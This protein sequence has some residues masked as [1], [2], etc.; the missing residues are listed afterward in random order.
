M[1]PTNICMRSDRKWKRLEHLAYTVRKDIL[2]ISYNA[3]V[4]HI[5]PALS[6]VDILT[7]LYFGILRAKADRFILSKG[8]AAAAL[9]AVL[10]QKGHITKK[11][12]AT[13]CRQGGAFGDHPD[14]DPNRGI[15]LTTG[16]LGHGLSVGAGMA[17]GLSRGAGSRSAGPKS[18]IFVLISDAELNEGSIWEAAMFAGHHRLSNLTAIIDNN[19]QQAFGKTKEVL[20]TRPLDKKW[21]SFGWD[22]DIVNGHSHTQLSRALAKRSKNKPR[23]VIA[24]T[25]AGYG[26]SFMQRK[27]DWHYWPM[28]E[29]QYK[30]SINDIK[31]TRSNE[32]VTAARVPSSARSPKECY[33]EQV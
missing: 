19:G 22:V 12:L 26:V 20:D 15:E 30:Q 13:F 1:L 9:F 16:S 29:K 17:I 31:R 18:R 24:N 11:A 6:I 2:D 25:T 10:T 33:Q 28:S 27:V 8:H 3:H 32:R 14:F 4:G 21:Q 23:V 7:V 5:G